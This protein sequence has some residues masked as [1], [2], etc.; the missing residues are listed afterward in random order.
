MMGS[1]LGEF[2]ILNFKIILKLT[3]Y[4]NSQENLK[5]F[6]DVIYKHSHRIFKKEKNKETNLTVMRY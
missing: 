1:I 5:M 6:M 4:T 2:G 3:K